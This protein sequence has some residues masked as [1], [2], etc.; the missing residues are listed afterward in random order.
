MPLLWFGVFSAPDYIAKPNAAFSS[1]LLHWTAELGPE[2]Y[3]AAL[4]S[5]RSEIAA[6][7]TY[8][9][10]FTYRLRS[11]F[12]GDPWKLFSFLYHNQPSSCCMYVDTGRW[13]ICSASPE[14]FFSLKGSTLTVRPM[15]G[16]LR[17][18]R[19]A[20]ED[21]SLAGQLHRSEK[22]R[23][24][25]LMIVDMMRSD[26]GRVCEVGSMKVPRLFEVERHPTVLQMTSTVTG[27][28]GASFSR[29]ISALFPPASVTGAPKVE[30]MRILAR[31]ERSPREA[32]TGSIGYFSPAREARFNVAI[33][34]V[35]F[36]QQAGF[37]RCGSGVASPGTRHPSKNIRS[38]C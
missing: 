16:T 26:L 31:T 9:A 5:I 27:T 7:S 3:R 19:W 37:A 28:T 15:K 12:T 29:I 21:E 13:A 33:R 34:T 2:E 20:D 8:Q 14:L 22:D 25:N 18:G 36:D 32:Y 10:N 23:A 38:V 6:G 1:S 4:R 17:R 11:P 35:I 24:E 30:T